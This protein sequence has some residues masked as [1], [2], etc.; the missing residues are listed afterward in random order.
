MEATTETGVSVRAVTPDEVHFYREHGWV[1]L[2]GLIDPDTADQLRDGA[3]KLMGVRAEEEDLK[4]AG[5][6]DWFTQYFRPDREI[7]VFESVAHSPDLGRDAA[8]MLGGDVAVR[9]MVNLTCAKPPGKGITPFHQDHGFPIRG[10]TLAFW[11]ALNDMT[12]EMGTMRF[13]DGSHKLGWLSGNPL[14]WPS[15]HEYTTLSP[16]LSYQRGDATIHGSLTV[17]GSPENLTDTVRWAFVVNFSPANAE[18]TGLPEGLET[19]FD[20]DLRSRLVMG[21]PMDVPEFPVVYTPGR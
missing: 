6:L 18:Y 15:L 14:D 4:G 9:S 19:F 1:F 12:P 10:E 21:K 2:P 3:A 17:H 13:Y 8:L 20:A 7:E 5:K 11:I 16:P